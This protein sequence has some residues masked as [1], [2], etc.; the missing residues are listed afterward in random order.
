MNVIVSLWAICFIAFFVMLQMGFYGA[1]NF[2][3]D[4]VPPHGIGFG[5]GDKVFFDENTLHSKDAKQGL[6]HWVIPS[7]IGRVKGFCACL[8]DLAV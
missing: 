2:F 8:N 3:H 4:R 6:S 5:N 7:I 1:A